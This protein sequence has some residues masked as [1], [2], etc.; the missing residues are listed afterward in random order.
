MSTRS[1]NREKSAIAILVGFSLPLILSG[2]LQQLYNWA[3]AFIVGNVEGE[4]ALA[5]IGATGT[6][7]NFYITVMVGFTTGLSILFAHKYGSGRI[8]SIKSILSTFLVVL[9]CVFLLATVLG[10][11][12]AAPFLRLLHTPEDIF[13]LS[14]EYLQIVLLGIPFL[15]VYN[16]YF[17]ALRAVGDS[18][19][20]FWAILISAL[21]NVGLDILFVAVF[22]WS[23]A[24]AAAATVIS[25]TAMAVFIIVYAGKI[26]ESMRFKIGRNM[27]DR[28]M[29]KAGLHMGMPPTIQSSVGAFGNLILQNFMN[30]FGT[31]TVAAITTAYRVDT[32][33]L[34]PV[35]NLGSAISTMVAQA[36]GAGDRQK[37]RAFI[38]SG[39]ILMIGIALMMTLIIIPFG[40]YLIAMFGVEAEATAIGVAF[41]RHIAGFYVIY[42]LAMVLRGAIEGI[43]DVTFSSIAGII[44]LIARIIMSYTL[45]G[46]WDNMVIALAEAL[47]WV[48]ILFLYLWRFLSKRRELG[49]H[50]GTD[51]R[52][53]SKTGLNK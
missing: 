15:T 25:Q 21:I 35:I 27:V 2:V 41:F 14:M 52:S 5:A 1:D 38:R 39:T 28:E 40:G 45:V 33:I 36:D 48:L 6:V 53:G 34:L 20:P 44:S 47:S 32:I 29:L 17:A 42:G 46:L 7:I 13:V 30:S 22:H 18:K 8:D 51:L 16:V 23:V 43:G 19:A 11:L 37:I 50:D 3:D 4:L 31:L 10:E 24:G 12:F 9:V 49:F 26:H